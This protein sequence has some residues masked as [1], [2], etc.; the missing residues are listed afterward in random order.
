MGKYVFLEKK[1]QKTFAR[2]LTQSDCAL[3]APS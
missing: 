1:K 2:S 3:G